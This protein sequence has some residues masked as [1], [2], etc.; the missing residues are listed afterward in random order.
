[1]SK[2]TV[3]GLFSG[4]GGIERAFSQAG[5]TISWAND[6]DDKA[7]ETYKVI[8][9]HDHYIGNK[10][11]PVEKIL[12]NSYKE[13]LSY[14]DVLVGGFP[15][16]AFSIAGY[17]KGFNDSRGNVFFRIIEVLNHLKET[18]E[19]P[20]ALLLENVKNFTYKRRLF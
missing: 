9:G 8:I 4:V 13:T 15:C 12:Q 18:S 7:H 3:G 17:R 10:A 2:L 5:F 20:K 19:L 6:M 1:M 16:Q 11:M 14:V